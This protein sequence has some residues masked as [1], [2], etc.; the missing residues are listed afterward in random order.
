MGAKGR[1]QSIP[2]F[3]N[4]MR[5]LEVNTSPTRQKRKAPLYLS[6]QL[7]QLRR[8]TSSDNKP[9]I[10][11]PGKPLLEKVVEI[12]PK[13]PTL[14]RPPLEKGGGSTKF[15]H[16][17]AEDG[18]QDGRKY[19]KEWIMTVEDERL[20]ERRAES[21][22]TENGHLCEFDVPQLSV[23]YQKVRKSVG[24]SQREEGS[25]STPNI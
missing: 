16:E 2:V 21:Q 20:T 13:V 3:F 1:K 22:P 8:L 9:K 17:L 6:S 4:W 24:Y 18:R 7:F 25:R 19:S 14:R 15:E 11:M 5:R 12:P 23:S 10:S